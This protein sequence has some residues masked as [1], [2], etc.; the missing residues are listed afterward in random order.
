[1]RWSN[2]VKSTFH[3]SEKEFNVPGRLYRI[4]Y[5]QTDAHAHALSHILP[6]TNAHNCYH[7]MTVQSHTPFILPLLRVTGSKIWFPPH[8]SLHNAISPA[9]NCQDNLYQSR[10]ES[11]ESLSGFSS[12]RQ[13]KQGGGDNRYFPSGRGTDTSAASLSHLDQRHL[14]KKCLEEMETERRSNPSTRCLSHDFI[15]LCHIRGEHNLCQV[16]LCVYVYVRV[17]VCNAWALNYALSVNLCLLNLRESIKEPGLLRLALLVLV[18][19]W[20]PKPKILFCL[21]VVLHLRN[22]SLLYIY[23]LISFTY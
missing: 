4:A 10:G 16:F 21:F 15:L 18:H 8:N 2:F 9:L 17:C 22:Y 19:L 5:M 14:V 7:I 12:A 6:C 13:E 11:P 3:Y 23:F 20:I 1:M